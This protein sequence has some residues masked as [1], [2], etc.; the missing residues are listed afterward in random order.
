[1]LKSTR[2]ILIIKIYI[3]KKWT[4][5]HESLDELFLNNNKNMWCPIIY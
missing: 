3:L 5:Y 2:H 4:I 1:M